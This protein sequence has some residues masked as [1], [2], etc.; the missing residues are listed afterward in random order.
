[1]T[2]TPLSRSIRSVRQ[3]IW[4]SALY[5]R[6]RRIAAD[7]TRPVRC[8]EL[9]LI[10]RQDLTL[11]INVSDADV[12]IEIEQASSED[13]EQA[14]SL[15]PV[16][17]RLEIFRREIFRWRLENGCGCF[18]ARAGS[19]LVAYNWLRLRPGVD[20]G[21]MI[22]LADREAFHFDSYVDENW[23]GHRIEAAL[24][25]RMRL[26]EKQRG[27]TEAY[28]KISTFNRKSLKSSR[29]MGWKPT[30]LVL[31]VRGSRRGGWPIITLWG[32]AH[33][34]MRLRRK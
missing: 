1:M 33:P 29:R 30:G 5:R 19:E 3:T 26:F 24:S 32:S 2:D 14:A 15:H 18:I 21:D 4:S 31:R 28:T 12:K 9:A 34:L 11:P 13:V 7:L 23:R 16:G 8:I 17:S 6:T 25:S 22:S 27:Y 10:F 20:D